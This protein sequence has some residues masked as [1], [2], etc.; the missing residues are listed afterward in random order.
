MNIK[1]K[2]LTVLIFCFSAIAMA[3]PQKVIFDTDMGNDCDDVVAFQMLLS[4]VKSGK[5]D[6]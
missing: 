4:Y 6:L 5:A 3:V 1:N 2:I